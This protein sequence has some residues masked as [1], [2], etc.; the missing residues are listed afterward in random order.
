MMR[1]TLQP[2]VAAAVPAVAMPD[3]RWDPLMAVLFAYVLVDI[4]RLH[5]LFPA[6]E[7]LHP[8]LVC[9][10]AAVVLCA[11]TRN[12]LREASA[13]RH[14]VTYLVV[15]LCAWAVLS[16]PGSVYPGGSFSFLIDFCKTLLIA[17][18][19]VIAVRGPRDVERLLFAFFVAA[20]IY[21]LVVLS[22]FRIGSGERLAE[23]YT[24]DANDLALFLVCAVPFGLYLALRSRG[25]ARRALAIAALPSFATVIVWTG[26]RG[27]LLALG[28]V[29]LLVLATWKFISLR[30]RLLGVAVAVVVFLGSANASYWQV[31]STILDPSED[32]NVT[33]VNG[34]VQVWKRGLGYMIDNPVLGVG[35][36]AFPSAEG[37]LSEVARNLPPGQ[38]FKWSAAHN[39]FVQVGA[40]LGVPGL[41]MFCALA[42]QLI[43]LAARLSR[44]RPGPP[45]LAPPGPAL[46]GL[47]VPTFAGFYVAAFFLSQAYSSVL[48][49]LAALVLG[50]YRL[51]YRQRAFLAA[52][53]VRRA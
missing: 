49:F 23:L 27:G 8:A 1:S 35:L 6:L 37:R 19:M 32:Y 7:P 17:F 21:A 12:V 47:L 28:A 53:P 29:M 44:P 24:Y 4:G 46:A 36:N 22:R 18:V 51:A 26:S 15:G 48:Y 13:V 16:V 39:S 10:A 45:I 42:W 38:G 40:E 25:L 9:G 31:A 14:P 52:W 3:A 30:W 43:R 50:L 2:R 5:L 34:R 41:L 11:L 33:S 20:V